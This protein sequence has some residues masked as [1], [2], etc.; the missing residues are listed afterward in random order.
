MK[1]TVDGDYLEGTSEYKQFYWISDGEKFDWDQVHSRSGGSLSSAGGVIQMY[2]G[3]GSWDYGYAWTKPWEDRGWFVRYK[4]AG[5]LGNEDAAACWLK[6]KM[7]VDN[8]EKNY[9]D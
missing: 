3:D 6:R 9:F 4:D 7:N 2:Q 1:P 8:F 5:E